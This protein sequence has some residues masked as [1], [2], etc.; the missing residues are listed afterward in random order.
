MRIEEEIKLDYADVLLRPKRSTLTSRKEVDLERELTFYHSPKK[1]KGI[2][3]MTANM[4]TCGTFEMAKVLSEYKIIT[5]FHK[6]YETFD[7]EEFFKDFHNP[8]FVA[9]NL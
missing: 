1:W 6:Y 7:Y 8:D 9:Y 5:T 4:A 3:I 2:P